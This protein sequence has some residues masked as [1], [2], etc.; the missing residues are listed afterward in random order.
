MNDEIEFLVSS[1]TQ[2]CY[3]ESLIKSR[4]MLA[5]SAKQ[6]A[7]LDRIDEVIALELQVAK[8]GAEKAI[9]EITKLTTKDNV[10]VVPLTKDK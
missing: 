2:S 5:A 9:S 7:L 4:E 8:M 10:K 1:D 6:T 3:L